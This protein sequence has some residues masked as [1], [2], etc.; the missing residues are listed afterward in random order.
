PAS[1]GPAS[2][3][4]PLDAL[5]WAHN[6]TSTGV[7]LPVLR[8]PGHE[9]ALVIID[10]TSAA[11]A[12]EVD[13]ANA[14]AYYFAPQKSFAGD[15]GLWLA[16]LS[17][18]AQ[19]RIAELESSARWIPPFLS[20]AIALENSRKDQ[21]YNTPAIATLLLLADQVEWMLAGG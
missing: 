10:A 21:T 7:S 6:E 13:L 16:L 18:A 12:L 11:G 8:P 15:G 9:G 4:E 2:A 3:D 5:A 1:I 19:E 17:P 20:L 14:D